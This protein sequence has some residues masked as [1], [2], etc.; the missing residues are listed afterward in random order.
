MLSRDMPQAGD[1]IRAP[2]L[3]LWSAHMNALGVDQVVP[4]IGMGLPLSLQSIR[5]SRKS[6]CLSTWMSTRSLLFP[7][8]A[9]PISPHSVLEKFT[10]FLLVYEFALLVTFSCSIA[11]N[12]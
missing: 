11:D 12:V 5:P 7:S 2:W 9:V 8:R 10:N 3:T 4:G 6:P 1:R